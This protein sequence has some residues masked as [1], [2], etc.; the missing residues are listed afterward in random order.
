MSGL[1]GLLRAVLDRPSYLA[2]VG[3]VFCGTVIRWPLPGVRLP[4]V[5]SEWSG[6][7]LILCGS[8][9]AINS[10][11]ALLCTVKAVVRAVSDGVHCIE[12]SE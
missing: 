2:A 11:L 4:A 12:G 8:F 5:I 1:A 10:G 3:L 6:V 7:E 9:L